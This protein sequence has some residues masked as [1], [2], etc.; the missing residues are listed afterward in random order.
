MEE[1]KKQFA[2]NTLEKYKK[3][4][5]LKEQLQNDQTADDTPQIPSNPD[6]DLTNSVYFQP[7]AVVN[8]P[9]PFSTGKSQNPAITTAFEASVQQ[10]AATQMRNAFPEITALTKT[11]TG[12][13]A[14][15][16]DKVELKDTMTSPIHSKPFETTTQNT[17]TA[18]QTLDKN[19]QNTQTSSNINDT[20]DTQTSLC[21]ID[22]K[23]T[24]TTI[25]TVDRSLQAIATETSVIDQECQTSASKQEGILTAK[26]LELQ[27]TVDQLKARITNQD[28]MVER[29]KYLEAALVKEQRLVVL[30]SSEVESIPDMIQKYH[31]ERFNLRQ[32][33][34]TKT[35]GS[36]VDTF[37]KISIPCDSCYSNKLIVL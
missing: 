10:T 3:K 31:Q 36:E 37:K 17:Q 5:L 29:I 14:A 8:S 6:S 19:E 1:E 21:E 23:T 20:K 27:Q 34:N 30:L 25:A 22:I 16:T 4:R 15:Q 11:T 9:S 33:G 26:L 7:E 24:Q 2:R 28:L 13:Q 18:I 32:A 35:S 12:V